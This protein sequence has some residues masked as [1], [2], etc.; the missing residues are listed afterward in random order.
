MKASVKSKRI[1]LLLVPLLFVSC[2]F[3][4]RYA[5]ERY[6]GFSDAGLRVVVR[7][8]LY[9]YIHGTVEGEGKLLADMPDSV[10]REM[11][12]RKAR[13]RA[14]HLCRYCYRDEARNLCGAGV[15]PEDFR[16]E[17]LFMNC[18]DTFCE[19]ICQISASQ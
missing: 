4:Q 5:R 9:Q 1:Y 14:W 19:G 3:S 6:E 13:L 18:S 12:L 8:S 11:I 7:V 17:L 15:Q 16:S 10:V 2:T